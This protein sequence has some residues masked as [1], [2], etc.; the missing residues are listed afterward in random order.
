[1][2]CKHI[3]YGAGCQ[4][5]ISTSCPRTWRGKVIILH[6]CRAACRRCALIENTPGSSAAPLFVE[7]FTL[8]STFILEERSVSLL[9]QSVSSV[10]ELKLSG[11]AGEAGVTTLAGQK[12][13]H[14]SIHPSFRA[15]RPGGS[16]SWSRVPVGREQEQDCHSGSCRNIQ[17][18]K[19][20][21]NF[22]WVMEARSR[23]EG[24]FTHRWKIT[25]SS[26]CLFLF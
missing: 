18:Q 21:A 8:W 20:G 23:S 24:L 10:V 7:K 15:E 1:M 6:G 14:P 25:W 3:D 17:E 11:W 19:S 26:V 22:T 5:V 9:E 2:R 12:V 13:N 16:L 4:R